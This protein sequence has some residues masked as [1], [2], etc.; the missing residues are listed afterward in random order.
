MDK[1]QPGKS[2]MVKS[3]SE[4]LS[5]L[6]ENG[7][8]EGLPFLPEM[9]KYCEKTF[10]IQRR[11]KKLIQE[12]VGPKMRRIKNVVLLKGTVCDGEFHEKCQRMC[13]PLWKTAWLTQEHRYN[14][15]SIGKK[16][17]DDEQ[18]PSMARLRLSQGRR[19]QV[20][21]L[22]NATSPLPLWHPLRHIWDITEGTYTLGEY[23]QYVL[24]KLYQKT[25][26]KL[27][28]KPIERRPVSRPNV[29]FP[30]LGLN[31]GDLVEVRPESEIRSTLDDKNKA[32]GL[33][34]M[35]GMWKY[36]GG[37]FRVL[38]RVDRMI[39]EKTGDIRK[40]NRTVILQGITC[41]GQA[42]GGCQRGCYVFWKDIWLKRID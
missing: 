17:E 16:N 30:E 18:V 2:V 9:A 40:L 38:A 5:T 36:C 42:H 6:D 24:T 32:G 10:Y 34:F 21:E 37:R 33:Y 7:S 28:A 29:I 19:C 13:S 12:G 3:L 11:V 23:L 1:F 39:S 22:I 35:P 25:L 14:P 15:I 8:Y 41:D 20:T 31:P 26:K 27:L 4:I